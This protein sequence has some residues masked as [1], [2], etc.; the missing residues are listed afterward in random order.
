MT[1]VE[2]LVV[3]AIVAV[4]LALLLPAISRAREQSRTAVCLANLKHIGQGLHLYALDNHDFLPPRQMSSGSDA[5]RIDPGSTWTGPPNYSYFRGGAWS[6]QIFVGQYVG[7]TNGDNMHPQ[8]TWTTVKPRSALV[9]PSDRYH[10]VDSEGTHVSYAMGNNSTFITPKWGYHNLRR[11][12]SYKNP[13]L[14]LTIVDGLNVSFAPGGFTPA[15]FKFYGNL[16]SDKNL[17]FDYQGNPSSI[18]N[19]A[20]RHNNEKGTNVLFVD[21]HATYMEDLK[22]AWDRKEFTYQLTE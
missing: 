13:Q 5:Q 12:D 16:D 18:Y 2:L 20:R 11:L 21:G 4:L 15:D 14:E 17:V 9:C 8:Y 6:D 22:Q 1:L 7:S 10:E 19:W 3:I